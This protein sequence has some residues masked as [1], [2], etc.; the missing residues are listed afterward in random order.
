MI[1]DMRY[2]TENQKK[3]RNLHTQFNPKSKARNTN[4]LS[5]KTIMKKEYNNSKN[6]IN[7]LIIF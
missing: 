5:Q 4:D 7:M 2:I 1:Q 3:F 6:L